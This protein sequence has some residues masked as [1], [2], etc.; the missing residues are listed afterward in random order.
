MRALVADPSAPHGL[1][2]AEAPEPVPAPGQALV[3]VAATSLNYG[4]LSGAK[5]QVP[6]TVL[7]WDCAGTLVRAASDGSGPAKGSRV[8]TFGGQGAWAELR[9]ADTAE[10]AVVPDG[11]DLGAASALPV[12]GV[13]ALR[14]LRRFGFIA[15]ERILVTGASG[16]VGRFAV[17]LAAIAGAQVIASVGRPERGAGLTEIGAAQIVVGLDGIDQPV[18][19]V[20]DNVGGQQLA[21]A[22]ALLAENGSLQS[23]G[24]TANEPTVFA[25]YATVGIRRSIEAFTMGGHLAGDLGYLVGLLAADKLDPQIGWRG[26]WERAEE[27]AD[28]LVG[29]QVAGKAVLDIT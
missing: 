23:I 6:G 19:G 5:H 25:P 9:A 3:K 22:F 8:V 28:A 18:R 24:G 2:L 15:G 17:Q 1:R 4:E 7:G 11:V 21:D 14:A 12:A 20:I 26:S 10:M 13:T 27:A 16:G 29:R